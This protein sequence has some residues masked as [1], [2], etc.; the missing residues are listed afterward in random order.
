M[1]TLLRFFG[2]QSSHSLFVRDLDPKFS[3]Y[4]KFGASR[5]FRRLSQIY[6]MCWK[7]VTPHAQ[8]ERGKVIGVGVHICVYMFVDQKKF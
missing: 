7:I 2:Q 4:H 6:Q 5:S 1:D 3:V 8:R